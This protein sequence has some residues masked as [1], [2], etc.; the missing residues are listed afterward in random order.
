MAALAALTLAAAGCP[1]SKEDCPSGQV[2]CGELCTDPATFQTDPGNCGACGILCGV[3][4][5]A[6]GVCQCEG[7]TSCPDRNPRCADTANDPNNCGTCGNACQRVGEGCVG[8]LCACVAPK[9]DDCDAFC[10]D[11]LTDVDNCGVDADAGCGNACAIPGQSC[12]GGTCGCFAPRD[13]NCTTFCTD[14]LTDAQNC[15]A[16]AASGCGNACPLTNDVCVGGTCRCP[17]STTPCPTVSPSTCVNTATDPQNCG[18]CGTTCTGGR[19]CSGSACRCPGSQT[20]C[21]GTCAD[22]ATDEQNCGSCGRACA[23][24]L[25]CTGGDCTCPAAGGIACAQGA[26]CC[27][28]GVC[29]T[30]HANGLG[31]T[32]FDCAAL[33][34]HTLDQARLAALVWAPSG[35]PFESG[36]QCGLCLCR[37]TGTQAAVWCYA[38]SNAKGLVRVTNT[39]NCPAA[40]CP[41]TGDLAWH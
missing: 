37:Q 32:Y 25:V 35:T 1:S 8:G 28:S 21:G 30:A 4:T 19:V 31:Q 40:F 41:G 34:L 36:L 16:D 14:T 26:S 3:G 7:A 13:D 2:L 27:P 6:G 11:T 20:E 9:D 10:T 29:Q 12:S 24:G 22:T 17:T 23:A 38:G 33:D 18:A 39:P 15:G 5:C